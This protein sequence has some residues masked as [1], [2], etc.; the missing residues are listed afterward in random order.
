MQR[1]GRWRPT[2]Q[3]A[4][5]LLSTETIVVN[6]TTYN[7]PGR[8]WRPTVGICLDGTS[9][10]YIV[11]AIRAGAMPNLQ[12][13]T[14]GH[15]EAIPSAA[16]GCSR[17]L[18]AAVMPT[19]TNPNNVSI[20]TGTTPRVHGI[21]GN[22]FYDAERDEDVHMNAA[23]Y[24]RAPT[25]FSEMER[26][27]V[28]VIVTTAKQKLYDLLAAN[29]DLSQSIVVASET[30]EDQTTTAHLAR[31]GIEGGIRALLPSY[32]TTPGIYDP[33]ISYH[34][35]DTALA[36]LQRHMEQS[37]MTPAMVYCSTTDFVQ[38][39]FVPGSPEANEFCAAVDE[40][41]GRFDS[42]C[43]AMIGITADHGMNDKVK[44]DGTPNICY[45][46]PVV[47]RVGVKCRIVLPITDAYVRHHGGLGSFAMLHFDNKRDAREA[48]GE[49]CRM[50]G[51]YTIVNK[52]AAADEMSLPKDRLGDIVL[53]A[54][55]DFVFASSPE[56][57]DLSQLDPGVKLRSHGGFSEMTVPM[58]FNFKLNDAYAK[59]LHSG[60]MRNFHLFEALCNGAGQQTMHD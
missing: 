54:K 49:L 20:A 26:R 27:G 58:Y 33:R 24:I 35:L 50:R 7:Q 23:S 1:L 9:V 17:G 57:H 2:R 3:P 48:H 22:Y 31:H 21:S 44:Y 29:L 43:S 15:W 47:D 19:F 8:G 6:R 42:E 38:H 18:A 30:A 59:R 16:P 40:R 10:E 36:L 13:W 45:L 37:P 28:K 32:A 56:E 5:R 41:L 53:V 25:I 39:Q 52:A 51:M 14:S 60:E 46:R 4:R 12:N 11:E 34:S 55:R